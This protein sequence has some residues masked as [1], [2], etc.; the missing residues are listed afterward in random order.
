MLTTLSDMSLLVHS[1]RKVDA[2]GHVD[3]FW[4][5]A[6]G[7]TI[8]E[9]GTGDGWRKH[10]D[11]VSPQSIV[12]G[13]GHW[14]TPGFIDLHGHG[15][16]GHA[17]DDGPAGIRAG[18]AVH[19]RRGTTR[20]VV[21]LVANPL[22]SLER[23]LAGIADVAELDPLILG[24][25]LEGPYLASRRR[26]AHSPDHIRAPQ[27]AEVERLIAASRGTLRQITIAPELPGALES[28]DVLT[29]AGVTVA[30]GHT[31]A[32]FDEAREAFQ[33]GA[34]LLTH[35]FNAMEGIHHRRPGPV[36][37]AMENPLVTLELI[38]DG[39]H[40]HPSVARLLFAGAPGRIA[41]ITDAMAAAGSA[42]GDYRLGDLN[43]TVKGGQALLSGT[44]TIAGSTLTQDAAL[45]LAITEA[46]VSP[47]VAVGALTH[48]PARALGIEAQHGLLR[49]GHVAD[50]VL[51]DSRWHVLRVWACGAIVPTDGP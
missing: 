36:V 27:P 31:E 35:A 48:T 23:S 6:D 18:L 42:D 19:R 25:H 46:G 2:D 14:L 17:F 11:R 12:D 13:G 20:S 50:A 51:L 10:A 15:G 39:L 41:L 21:S 26:G 4:L 44:A 49:P 45:R 38:L 24:S 16:G 47:E 9:T 5:V 37:A 3:D 43:V 40:V 7:L 22:D 32:G 29:A 28:I 30:V 1:V 34:R 33:R 8:T